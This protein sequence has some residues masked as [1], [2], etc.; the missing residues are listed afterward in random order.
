MFRTYRNF[1]IV[2]FLWVLARA[3]LW[4]A[5]EPRAERLSLNMQ[6]VRP[7]FGKTGRHLLVLRLT[8]FDPLRNSATGR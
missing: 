5:A 4:R 2:P 1:G 7:L 8:G 3:R 6:V